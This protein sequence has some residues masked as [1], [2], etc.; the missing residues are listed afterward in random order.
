MIVTVM[1]LMFL[2][3]GACGDRGKGKYDEQL[4]MHSSSDVTC[5][6]KRARARRTN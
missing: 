5:A 1:S 4:C 3:D 6:H 2:R